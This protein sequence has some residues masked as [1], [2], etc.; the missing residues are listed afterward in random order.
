MFSKF[1]IYPL[2]APHWTPHSELTVLS[3]SLMF[4][5]LYAFL[6]SVPHP[7]GVRRTSNF[8]FPRKQ[9]DF[10]VLFSFAVNVLA[11]YPY[12]LDTV[13]TQ[14]WRFLDVKVIFL[15]KIILF[16]FFKIFCNIYFFHFS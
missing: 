11:K 10:L 9:P 7:L 2:L 12:D 16:A 8:E 5:S 13:V 6:N 1:Q 3:S 14:S 4:L 15:I